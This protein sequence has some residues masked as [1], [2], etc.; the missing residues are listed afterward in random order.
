MDRADPELLLQSK[1]RRERI[2][3]INARL[4]AYFLQ[5]NA[6]APPRDYDNLLAQAFS[7]H[8]RY[9]PDPINEDDAGR[10]ADEARKTRS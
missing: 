7:G 10:W 8:D 1:M 9:R 2:R 3:A 6:I 5:L 4:R